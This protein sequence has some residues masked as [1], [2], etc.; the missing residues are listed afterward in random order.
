MVILVAPSASSHPSNYRLEMTMKKID[1]FLTANVLQDSLSILVE[2]EKEK[3]DKLDDTGPIIDLLFEKIKA[4]RLAWRSA[5]KSPQDEIIMKKEWL[6]V[7]ILAGIRTIEQIQFGL[8]KI[9]LLNTPWFP[10]AVEFLGFC[11]PTP[12][13]IGA[14]NVDDA[15]KEACKNSYPDGA[16]KKWTH[17]CIRYA[18]Q[19]SDSFFLRTESKQKTYPV[20]EKN[21]LDAVSQYGDGKILNQIENKKKDTP[22]N[23][24]KYQE[25]WGSCPSRKSYQEFL[26][27][28]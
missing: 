23:R 16:P 2:L 21:Y 25:K 18:T 27:E 3:Q 13:D 6:E 9:A 12:E 1:A 5:I 11:T 7:F 15:Y 10:S 26:D 20:F 24:I 4:K 22:E 14:P 19:K 8:E 28:L 17:P